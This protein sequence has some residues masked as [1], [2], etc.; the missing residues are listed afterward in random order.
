MRI[1]VIGGT[2]GDERT[3][4]EVAVHLMNSKFQGIDALISNRRAV[5]L[6]KRFVETD[7]NRSFGV[8]HPKSYE[9]F[10]ARMISSKL[11]QYDLVLDFHN[12]TS[13]TTC[14]IVTTEKPSNI[15]IAVLEAFG[16]RKCIIMPAGHSLCG[17]IPQTAIGLE[18]SRSDKKFSKDFLV[19]KIKRIRKEMLIFSSEAKSLRFYYHCGQKVTMT[20][21]KLAGLSIHDFSDFRFIEEEIA[22]T[23][24]IE[25]PSVPFLLRE[26]AYGEEFAFNVANLKTERRLT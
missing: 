4:I 16:L 6:G 7:L 25:F 10:R 11:R 20:Q 15:Q 2:H 26:K 23:L 9:E 22:R 13:K 17:Q 8:E 19:D 21:L 14:G 18:I 1:L 24:G 3:G 5:N 12:T